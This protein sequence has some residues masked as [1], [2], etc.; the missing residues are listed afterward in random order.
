MTNKKISFK[1]LNSRLSLIPGNYVDDEDKVHI[2]RDKNTRVNSLDADIVTAPTE[3]SLSESA[4]E[5]F[6]HYSHSP[7][8]FLDPKKHG[9]G[10]TDAADKRLYNDGLSKSPLANRVYFYI[11][12]GPEMPKREQGIGIHPHEVK[13]SSL[14]MFDPDNISDVESQ[15]Y[16]QRKQTIKNKL[17]V[18][19]GSANEM[20]VKEMGY[21]GYINR[22][23]NFAVAIRDEPIKV[24]VN[25]PPISL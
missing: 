20:A 17:G 21:D 13:P 7:R 24:D 2:N 16:N 9:S 6:I 3:I 12:N 23:Y 22:A 8:E 14:K 15:E 19:E 25:H 10:I 4:E 5:T 18:S 1:Q 11:K